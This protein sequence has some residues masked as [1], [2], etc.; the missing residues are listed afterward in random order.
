MEVPVCLVMFGSLGIVVLLFVRICTAEIRPKLSIMSIIIP[1]VIMWFFK[2]DICG[3]LQYN[4]CFCWGKVG[5]IIFLCTVMYILVNLAAY[6]F[7][8]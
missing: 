2:L 3:G 7:I 5:K 4:S 1:I 8:L 6:I